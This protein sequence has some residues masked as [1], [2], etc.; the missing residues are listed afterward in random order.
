MSDFSE[1]CMD[2]LSLGTFL[3][4]LL[5]KSSPPIFSMS[6]VLTS[7]G[8]GWKHWARSVSSR[9]HCVTLNAVKTGAS[10]G[11]VTSI[12]RWMAW[13]HSLEKKS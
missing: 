4:T 3:L 1:S 8:M 2:W 6:T 5:R 13:R 7:T 9:L 11:M 10:R 12:M